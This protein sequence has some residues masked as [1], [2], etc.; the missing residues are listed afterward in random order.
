MVNYFVLP[1]CSQIKDLKQK[2]N[3]KDYGNIFIIVVPDVMDLTEMAWSDSFLGIISLLL[4]Q[5]AMNKY[6]RYV[7]L[8]IYS[9]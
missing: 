3:K 2:E 1:V 4:I 8:H 9:P 7:L 5:F 6:K